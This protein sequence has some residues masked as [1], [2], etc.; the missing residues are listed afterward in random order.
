MKAAELRSKS[1]QELKT[2]LS[3][4]QRQQFKLRLVKS[5]GELVKTHEVRAVRR[6]IARVMMIM[7]Q[8]GK[9][10]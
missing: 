5:T 1:V 8:E 7:T 6:N 3:G 2:V 9:Q 10:K 4:L